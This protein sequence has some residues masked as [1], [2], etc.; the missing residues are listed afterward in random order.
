[1]NE[2]DL[3]LLVCNSQE[4][5]KLVKKRSEACRQMWSN[6][7]I[8]DNMII[9][10][11]RR[12]WCVEGDEN[13]RLF[14]A[15]INGRLRM[16]F[17]VVVDTEPGRVKA[18]EDVKEVVHSFFKGKYT[19]PEV[20][21]PILEYGGFNKLS[22]SEAKSLEVPFTDSEIKEAVWDCDGSKSPGPDGYNFVFI[23]RCW[24][25]LKY[26]IFKVLTDFNSHSFLPKVVSSSFNTLT[27]KVDKPLHLREY[28]PICL[29]GS[30]YKI[31]AKLLANRLKKVIGGLV[32]QCQ[33]TFV[34][35]RKMLEGVVVAN[36]I[37]DLATR[38]NK[39]CMSFKV[40]FEKV[41][42]CV[43]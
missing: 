7:K 31:M 1:M 19:E 40:D 22:I 28:R 25:L 35:G 26:D 23:K 15:Y 8:K 20:V 3:K 13:S 34:L 6:L 39:E 4:V 17:I 36:E 9:Q 37:I 29:V 38:D 16:K 33:T 42:D 12:R 24:F 41:Y 30:L 2:L 27:P 11:S 18:V 32:S 43:N 21:R 14:H 5:E 10:K